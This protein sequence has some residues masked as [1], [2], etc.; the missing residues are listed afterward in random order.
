MA[1]LA[2][3][4][5]LRDGRRLRVIDAPAELADALS[6][7]DGGSDGVL[8]FART[9]ADV[10]RHAD[11]LAAAAADVAGLA[12]A[13]YPKRGSGIDTDLS[14]DSGWDALDELG[15]APVRQV[16]LDDAWSALRFRRAEHVGGR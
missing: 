12:W 14:R 3:K 4:L 1:T 8:A 13:A 16:A 5:Q 10:R 2:S 15:M 7:V 9:S 11:D 6:E